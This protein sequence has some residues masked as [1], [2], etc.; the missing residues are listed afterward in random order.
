MLLVE[1]QD[2]L[3]VV[4]HILAKAETHV[5][6]HDDIDDKEGFNKLLRAVTVEMKVPGREVLGIVLDANDD[7]KA[8]WQSVSDRLKEVDVMLP[9]NP[10]L[11]GAI[12]QDTPRVGVWLMPDNQSPGQLED[13][14]STMIPGGDPAWSLAQEYIA[15]I[16][17]KKFASA[18]TSRA[19][20]HAW[21]A[22]R[23][24]PGRMGQAINRGDLGIEGALCQQFLTWI[25][26]LFG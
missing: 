17:D 25:T 20:L 12:I 22:S 1:G 6:S 13:F 9:K 3:H 8:R 11:G 15:A 2:D 23:K 5:L 14:V 19:E 16:P 21:L 24:H 18:K 10:V 4:G 7:P 26:D